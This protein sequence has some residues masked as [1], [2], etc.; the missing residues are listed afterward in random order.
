[1]S[2]RCIVIE[3]WEHASDET[4]IFHDYWYISYAIA[5][6]LDNWPTRADTIAAI[7]PTIEAW[8]WLEIRNPSLNYSDWQHTKIV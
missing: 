4:N 2:D 5:D 7:A 8:K 1:M 6:R 3:S